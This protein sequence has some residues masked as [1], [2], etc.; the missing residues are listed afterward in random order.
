MWPFFPHFLQPCRW[1]TYTKANIQDWTDLLGLL[2]MKVP[3]EWCAGINFPVG[4]L[5]ALSAATKRSACA[6]VIEG[7][8]LEA[9]VTRW[10]RSFYPRDA[11]LVF[12]PASATLGFDYIYS[13]IKRPGW[14]QRTSADHLS[15]NPCD[16]GWA[17]LQPAL[18]LR[19]LIVLYVNVWWSPTADRLRAL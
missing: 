10:A 19:A 3:H 1:W 13:R 6:A 15:A 18:A 14:A 4:R 9:T 8:R 7:T 17:Q 16:V 11:V 5:M 2:M 12:T